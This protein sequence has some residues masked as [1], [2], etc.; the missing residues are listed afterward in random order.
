MPFKNLFNEWFVRDTSRKIRAVQ[1]TKAQRGERLGTRAPHGYKK[2][3]NSR[4]KF[5][6]DEEAAAV[7]HRIFDLCAGGRGPSQITRQ[8]R[9]E[10]VL[11]RSIYAYKRFGLTHTGLA[12]D[13]PY[14]WDAKTVAHMLENELYIGNTLNM[15]YS[16][17]SYKDQRKPGDLGY[18]TTG[19]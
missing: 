10:K 17:K 1:R 9:E 4:G 15:K 7:V 5:V 19:T 14:N 6:I 11:C 13:K 18:C 16:N 8:L 3:K 12:V 2:D